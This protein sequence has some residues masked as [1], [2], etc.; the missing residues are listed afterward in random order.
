MCNC[1]ALYDAR[2]YPNE[3]AHDLLD[4]LDIFSCGPDHE[5]D[6]RWADRKD[7]PSVVPFG[8]E[9]DLMYKICFVVDHRIYDDPSWIH[10]EVYVVSL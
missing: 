10:T 7:H 4:L 1:A 9:M 3:P 6:I 8:N 5:V 2:V